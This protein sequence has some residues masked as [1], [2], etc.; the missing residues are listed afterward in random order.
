MGSDYAKG[1]GLAGLPR[2]GPFRGHEG[3]I[4]LNTMQSAL[5]RS[6]AQSPGRS[7]PAYAPGGSLPHVHV[8]LKFEPTIELDGDLISRSTFRRAYDASN[9]GELRIRAKAIEG[10]ITKAGIWT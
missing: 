3:E 5:F 4:I 2:T 6:L 10:F 8:T 9:R 1:T 7:A